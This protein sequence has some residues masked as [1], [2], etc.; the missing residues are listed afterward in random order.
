[1]VPVLAA[2]VSALAGRPVDAE[3]WADTVDRWQYGD[4][5]RPGDP[6]AEA[7]AAQM[8]A[9]LC[10]DGIEQM[11]A[12]ADEAVRGSATIRSLAAGSALFQGMA[13]VLADDLDGADASFQEAVR[14]G[15]QIGAPDSL[16][17]GLAERALIAMARNRWSQAEDLAE[18]ARVVVHRSKRKSAIEC[19]ALARSALHR[20]DLPA[21]RRELVSAQRLRPLLTYATPQ[22]AVQV[23]IE[24]ARVH[25]ALADTAGARM[26]MREIDELLRRRPGLGTLVGEAAALRVQ[27]ANEHSSGRPGASALT[28]AELRLLPLLCTHLSFPEVAADMFLS[29]STIKSQA[30]SLY[31]KLGVTSRSQAVTRARELGLLEQ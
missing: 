9:M 3:R 12:D 22:F 30:F 28:A 18:Q 8:R 14:A 23:R 5:G 15:E 4:A 11:R 10:R 31:R 16:M 25:L 26:L 21:V 20:G 17:S 27:L 6:L 29:P 13:R 2:I 7:W 19:S 24:L 1:M